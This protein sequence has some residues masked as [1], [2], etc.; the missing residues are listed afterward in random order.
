MNSEETSKLV[1]DTLS[2]ATAGGMIAGAGSILSGAA[3]ATTTS[4]SWLIFTTTVTAV[5]PWAV[6]G[7][8]AGG[9]AVAGIASYIKSKREIDDVNKHF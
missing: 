6:L 8:A 9:A 1:G 5:A 2:G 3:M 7:F 4:T